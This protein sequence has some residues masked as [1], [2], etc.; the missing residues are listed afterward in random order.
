MARWPRG[1]GGALLSGGL[2]VAGVVVVLVA[3]TRQ[4][5]APPDAVAAVPSASTSAATNTASVP[6]VPSPSARPPA[7]DLRDPLRGPRLTESAPVRLDIPRIGV[8]SSF[9]RLGLAPDGVLEVPADPAVAGWYAGA[10]AP[11]ALGP[12]VVV[13]HVTWDRTPGVFY[14]LAE[15]RPGDRVTVRRADRRIAVFAVRGVQAFAKD[16]FPTGAVYGPIDHAG[17]R[18]VTCAGPYDAQSGRFA[19]NLVVFADLVAVRR[20]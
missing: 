12:A 16:R 7:Q 17:L 4:T 15:L 6:P 5:P 2:A 13:G 18:L 8:A 20:S 10:P 9:E 19:G 11:G 3:L 14:R 1:A